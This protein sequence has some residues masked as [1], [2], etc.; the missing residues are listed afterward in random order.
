M[1]LNDAIYHHAPVKERKSKI[2]KPAIMNGELKRSIVKKRMLFNKLKNSK[3]SLNWENYRKQR[4]AVTNLKKK[5]M[6]CYFYERC[7]G[8]PK[9]KDFW[10]TIKSFLSKKGQGG[11]I[12]VVLSEGG[13]VVTDQPEVFTIF[14]NFFVNVAKDIGNGGHSMIKNFQTTLVS[15][16]SKTI[17]QKPQNFKESKLPKGLSALV[18]YVK[19]TYILSN[20]SNIHINI[21]LVVLD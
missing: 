17:S 3:T 13:K 18:S 12:P 14:D 2:Q 5:S 8:G 15:K 9:S 19:K 6:R 4:N 21:V 7:A 20:R 10:P 1:L 16:I 11:G